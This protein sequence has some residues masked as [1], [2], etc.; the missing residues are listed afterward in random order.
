MPKGTGVRPQQNRVVVE[1]HSPADRSAAPP[2]KARGRR[3][4]D[5]DAPDTKEVIL[6]VAEELFAR[7]GFHGVSLRDIAQRAKVNSALI[8]YY[9]ETKQRLFE[10]VFDRRS[11]TIN[12]E[13]MTRLSAYEERHGDNVTVEGA[14]AAFVDPLLDHLAGGGRGWE[15]FFAIVSQVNGTP[16]WGGEVIGRN[17]D[18]VV[19]KLIAV[20]HRALP[21][22]RLADL[23]ASYNLLSGALTLTMAQTGRVDKLSGGLCRSTDIP[24]F[25]SRLIAFATAGF[26]EVCAKPA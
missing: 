16:G 21:Q 24:F 5:P 22:A 13:R 12:A 7:R 2:Q 19:Q 11:I 1:P 25:H 4:H 14:I 17:F 6:D 9:F 3:L 26:R 10:S 15:N 23:Y 18:P 8:H 20:V